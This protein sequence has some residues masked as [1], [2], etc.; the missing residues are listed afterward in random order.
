M[1]IMGECAFGRMKAQYSILPPSIQT[2]ITFIIEEIDPIF[3]NYYSYFIELKRNG[4]SSTIV[5]Q[6]NREE[7][8]DDKKNDI[9]NWL[10]EDSTVLYD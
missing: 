7:F 9:Y 3:F 4:R 10:V 1:E 2:K 8:F 5:F 6:G